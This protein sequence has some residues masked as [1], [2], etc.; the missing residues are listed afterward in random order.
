MNDATPPAPAGAH[1][2]GG[3]LEGGPGGL[4]RTV[5]VPEAQTSNDNQ[6]G[7]V[8][9]LVKTYV[10]QETVGPLKGAGRWLAM[11]AA[12]AVALGLGLF[13]VVLGILRLLQTET[14]ETF[15][16][17]FSV[18]PYAIALVVCILVVGLAI[19]RIKKDTLQPKEPRR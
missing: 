4:L 8:L 7:E 17:N 2:F 9:E 10:R 13:L 16:G 11:G 3:V 15:D 5:L 19:S 18:V 1:R 12:G 14:S 6:I